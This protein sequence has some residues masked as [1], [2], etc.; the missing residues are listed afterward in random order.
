M[1]HRENAIDFVVIWVD[2]GDAAW[3][4]EKSHYLHTPEAESARDY[5]LIDAK[6]NRYRDWDNLRY[7]FRAVEK[8]APWVRK[9]HFVT[10]GQVPEWMN[11]GAPKL[12]LVDHRDFIP[13]E[14][15]PT[16]SSHPIELNLHR[17]PDL[18]ER[19]VYFNDDFFLTAPVQPEDFFV[20]SLPCDSAVE[21]PIQLPG[22]AFWNSIRLNDT[23]FASRHFDRNTVKQQHKDKWYPKCCPKDAIKNKLM[24]T[25]HK[26]HFFGIAI[27][28]LPQA[29]R[30]DALEAVWGLEPELLHQ[31]CTHKFRDRRDVSQYVFKYY[32]LLSGKFHPVDMRKM[33]HAFNSVWDPKAAA[34][35]IES[36]R[37]K[38]I[39]IND[40]DEMDFETAKALVNSAFE[41]LLPGKS[42]FE[43]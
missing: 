23:M 40:S 26:D 34:G 35:A 11:V 39:C 30:K 37:Y 36:S 10:C 15:L 16:F 27:H 5:G 33:G 1:Q 41:K 21:D 8:F 38:M 2:G 32:Q 14:Y 20:D 25:I 19:F 17:I 24:D 13:A 6:E 43:K 7:W 3:A 29:F 9:V 42:S 22:N 18:S 12:Q 31:T 28:H 4:K